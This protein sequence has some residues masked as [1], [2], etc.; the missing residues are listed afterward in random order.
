MLEELDS[1]AAML[2]V[3]RTIALLIG[4]LLL[5]LGYKLFKI[6]YFER[7]GELQAVWGARRFIL[8]QVAPGIFFALFGTIILCVGIWKPISVHKAA[9]P[10]SQSLTVG[11]T[12]P[13]RTALQKV[14][15]NQDITDAERTSISN[16]LQQHA[17]ERQERQE[18]QRRLPRRNYEAHQGTAVL[19]LRP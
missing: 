10:E 16:W 7:A 17:E 14:A 9:E 5:F 15:D 6:G 3:F 19:E 18:R 1:T 12:A 4:A 11:L 8:K 2:V 13:V